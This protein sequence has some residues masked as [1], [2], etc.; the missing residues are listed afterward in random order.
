MEIIFV[1]AATVFVFA[2]FSLVFYIKGRTDSKEAQLPTCAR[3]DCHRRQET[4]ERL[5]KY[6]KHTDEDIRNEPN[7]R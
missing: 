6:Q 3:C 5:F 2:L 7:N 4:H 1:L